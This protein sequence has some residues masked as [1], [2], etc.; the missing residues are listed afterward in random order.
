MK[1]CHAFFKF[2]KKFF[3]VFIDLDNVLIRQFLKPFAEGIVKAGRVGLH[4]VQ[5]R[6]DDEVFQEP[7]VIHFQKTR[8]IHF[9]KNKKHFLPKVVLQ[10]DRLKFCDRV[11]D[12]ARLIKFRYDLFAFDI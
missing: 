3:I 8:F 10:F 1:N 2:D 4:H 11:V 12:V 6:P 9:A 7:V 5:D